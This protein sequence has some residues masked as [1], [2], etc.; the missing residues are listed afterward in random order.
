MKPLLRGLESETNRVGFLLPMGL[1]PGQW[2]LF[3]NVRFAASDV[4]FVSK[5]LKA[6]VSFEQLQ[7]YDRA[8]VGRHRQLIRSELGVAAFQGF[9]KEMAFGKLGIW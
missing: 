5:L 9:A 4:K 6:S 3:Q 1:F 7:T 2:S 8:T